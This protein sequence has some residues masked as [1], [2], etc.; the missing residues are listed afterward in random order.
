MLGQQAAA[1]IAALCLFSLS[2]RCRHNKLFHNTTLQVNFLGGYHTASRLL[3]RPGAVPHLLQHIAAGKASPQLTTA[4]QTLLQDRA[5]DFSQGLSL[6]DARQT[7][8]LLSDAPVASTQ[9]G[10]ALQLLT[11]WSE[12]GPRQKGKLCSLGVAPALGQLAVQ[13]VALGD[14]GRELQG[15]MCR[16]VGWV[17]GL[18]E[19]D[20][21]WRALGYC[22]GRGL[23]MSSMTLCN[24]C[25]V[26]AEPLGSIKHQK[27]G[28]FCRCRHGDQALLHAVGL[29]LHPA[30]CSTC[31]SWSP[32]Q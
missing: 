25:S 7:I 32:P 21:A 9:Q 11:A 14:S 1:S 31:C 4:L 20:T 29:L 8:Q 27:Q 16:W 26:W 12:A 19:S 10:L 5:A 3:A 24:C 23:D 17:V 18:P 6:E 15:D 2:V 28:Q 13:A 22:S 30:G